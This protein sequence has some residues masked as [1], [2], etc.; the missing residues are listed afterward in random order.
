MGVSHFAHNVLVNSKTAHPPQAVDF[1]EKFWSNSRYV[2][3]LEGQIPHL[4]ELQRGSN[5]PPSR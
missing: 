3:S 5:P 2:A 4:L 1:F